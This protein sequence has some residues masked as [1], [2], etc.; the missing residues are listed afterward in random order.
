MWCYY[1]VY[2]Y[3]YSQSYIYPYSYNYCQPTYSNGTG[4]NYGCWGRRGN[5]CNCCNLGS[6]EVIY[7]A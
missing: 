3:N 6:S 2:G 4:Y 7:Y 1:P 5:L